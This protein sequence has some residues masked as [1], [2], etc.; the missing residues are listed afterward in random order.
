MINDDKQWEKNEK[1]LLVVDIK[2]FKQSMKI[3]LMK[4][5]DD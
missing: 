3:R 2:L 1:N 4:I 5:L